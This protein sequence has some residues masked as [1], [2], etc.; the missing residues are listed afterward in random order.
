MGVTGS[1]WS[2]KFSFDG[3]QGQL[4]RLQQHP[5]RFTLVT[6]I[7]QQSGWSKKFSFDDSQAQD[8]THWSAG[9]SHMCG[10][11]GIQCARL[12]HWANSLVYEARICGAAQFWWLRAVTCSGII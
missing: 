11:L 2:I 7:L 6:L 10:H 3:P 4:G 12:L 1:E 5:F 9:H 8:T